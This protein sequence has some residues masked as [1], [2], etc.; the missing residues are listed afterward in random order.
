MAKHHK[1]ITRMD[2]DDQSMHGYNVRLQL[3][4]TLFMSKMFSDLK[5]GGKRKAL[6]M[7]IEYRDKLLKKHNVQSRLNHHFNLKGPR[8]SFKPSTSGVIG[9]I[10]VAKHKEYESYYSWKGYWWDRE[11]D[12]IKQKSFS[13]IKYG[14]CEAFKMACK[15]RFNVCGPLYVYKKRSKYFTPCRIPVEHNF[16]DE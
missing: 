4:N 16:I 7:A 6:K 5:N 15:A 14:E 9:V 11:A 12:S 10:L 13:V 3:R 2:Y 1:F 8:Q